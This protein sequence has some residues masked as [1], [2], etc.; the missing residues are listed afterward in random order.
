MVKSSIWETGEI[1]ELDWTPEQLSA[2]IEKFLE[3]T[4]EI[5]EE[6]NDERT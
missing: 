4:K 5:D 2:D 6:D 3:K 1:I